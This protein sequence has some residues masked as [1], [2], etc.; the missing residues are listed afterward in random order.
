MWTSSCRSIHVLSE[1]LQKKYNE[2]SDNITQRFFSHS[3][4]FTLMSLGRVERR[5]KESGGRY[6]P[7]SILM[8][9]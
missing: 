8:P 1:P 2:G 9:T 5:E 7:A 3:R 4:F 6:K